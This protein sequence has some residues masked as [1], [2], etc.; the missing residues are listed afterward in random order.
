[1]AE[2]MGLNPRATF[3]AAGFQDRVITYRPVS[4]WYKMARCIRAFRTFIYDMLKNFRAFVPR[5]FSTDSGA[6]EDSRSRVLRT[7]STKPSACG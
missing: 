3:A 5:I 1:M 2:G 7:G 6:S 4:T